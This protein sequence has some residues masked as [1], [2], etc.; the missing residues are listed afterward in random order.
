MRASKTN[1]AVDKLDASVSHDQ[2]YRRLAFALLIGAEAIFLCWLMAGHRMPFAHDAF[3]YFIQQYYIANHLVNYGTFPLWVPYLTHGVVANWLYLPAANGIVSAL[4][5]LGHLAHKINFLNLFYAG[6]FLDE[7]ILLVGTWL[8]AGRFYKSL[9]TVVFVCLTVLGSCIWV[10]QPFLNFHFYYAVP[11]IIYCFH[12]FLEC[13]RWRYFLAGGQL[14]AFQALGNSLYFLPATTW[15]I[16]IYFLFCFLSNPKLVLG[17]V[18]RIQFGGAAIFSALAISIP[19]IAIYV[20]ASSGTDQLAVFSGERTA[21][22]FISLKTFLRHRPLASPERLIELLSGASP[23]WDYT[24]YMGSMGLSMAFL[25][26][27]TWKSKIHHHLLF[28]MIVLTL[29]ISGTFV[30]VMAYHGW[31]MMKYFNHPDGLVV[32]LKLFLC[33]F[34]GLGFERV[35]VERAFRKFEIALLGFLA[36]LALSWFLYAVQHVA[37]VERMIQDAS[38]FNR[39]FFLERAWVSGSFLLISVIVLAVFACVKIPAKWFIGLVMGIQLLDVS[40]YKVAQLTAGTVKLSPVQYDITQFT[41]LPFHKQRTG[42][43]GA[44]SERLKLLGDL[45]RFITDGGTRYW[46]VTS[47][48][49]M[50]NLAPTFRTDYWLRPLNHVLKIFCGQS[51]R[52]P[53]EAPCTFSERVH[54]FTYSGNGEAARKIAGVGEDKIQ[55]FDG[56]YTAESEEQI[57]RAMTEPNFSGDTLF[58]LPP[59]GSGE[60]TAGTSDLLVRHDPLAGNRLQLPYQVQYFDSNQIKIDIDAG[61]RSSAWLYYSDVWHPFWKATVNGKARDVVRA[62]VGYKAVRLDPGKNEVHFFFDSKL[63][64]CLQFFLSAWS[65]L[66]VLSILWFVWKVGSAD[67]RLFCAPAARDAP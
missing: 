20:F 53:A 56:A 48:L 45:N 61:D 40:S 21:Q 34:A 8:L 38:V 50:D 3:S 27:M 66:L 24:L 55:F 41:R 43:Y 60:M 28:V 57:A 42:D 11:L 12:Q 7:M 18:S 36:V 15:I 26:L 39:E 62:N 2:R 9:Q 58:L 4:L 31:P 63:L 5:F 49:M 14:L 17:Q 52:D 6:L 23:R 64:T 44:R 67:L 19:L 35:C 30:S 10:T 65:C 32:F 29:F 25:G 54:Y 51:L 59:E 16:F 47:F 37:V 13:G 46:V 1:P 22:G 33:F